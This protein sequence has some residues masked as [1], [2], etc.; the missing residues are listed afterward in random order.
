MLRIHISTPCVH[1]DG[2]AYLPVGHEVDH[3]GEPYLRYEPCPVCQ[4]SGSHDRWVT[5]Q[6]FLDLLDEEARKDPMQPD[7][8]ELAR[9]KPVTEY[10]D[11]REAAG[12]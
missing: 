3:Q 6:K 8:A 10:V 2:E 1:C 12:I 11:S 9:R 7:L 5:L 4:G